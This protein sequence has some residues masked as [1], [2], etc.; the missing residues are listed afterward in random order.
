MKTLL[1]AMFVAIAVVFGLEFGQYFAGKKWIKTQTDKYPSN[2][3]VKSQCD[4][5]ESMVIKH[6]AAYSLALI[7]EAIIVVLYILS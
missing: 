3:F 2:K 6:K 1:L 7:S 4:E 5:L